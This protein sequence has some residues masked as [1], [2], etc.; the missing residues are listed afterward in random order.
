[1]RWWGFKKHPNFFSLS[2]SLSYPRLLEACELLS[3]SVRPCFA[4]KGIIGNIVIFS[5]VYA[6]LEIAPDE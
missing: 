3:P 4:I 1:M 2:D 5:I 6:G